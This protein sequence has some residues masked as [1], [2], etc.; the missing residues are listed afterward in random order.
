MNFTYNKEKYQNVRLHGLDQ[1]NRDREESTP[2]VWIDKRNLEESLDLIEEL[3]YKYIHIQTFNIDFLNDDRLKKIEGI[4]IQHRIEDLSNFYNLNFSQIT[5]LGLPDD[6][7][8][9]FDFSLC[10]NLLY[11]GGRMPKYYKNIDKLYKL[12]YVRIFGYRKDNFNEFKELKNIRKMEVYSMNCTNLVGLSYLENLEELTLR[13]C[14]KLENLE[15]INELNTQLNSVK[16]SNCKRLSKISILRKLNK[17]K[18]LHLYEI[19]KIE[20]LEFLKYLD[21]IEDLSIN[22][23]VVGVTNADYYP[24]VKKLKELNQLSNLKYWD[25]LKEYLNNEVII[26]QEKDEMLS[27]LQLVLMRSPI[28]NWVRDPNE[29]YYWDIYSQ[30]N[31]DKAQQ[32]MIDLVN[33][34][35]S[36]NDMSEERKVECFK[37]CILKLNKH[38]EKY[39]GFIETVEREELCDFFDNLADAAGINVLDYDDGIADEWREW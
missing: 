31:C 20:S 24:L 22:P 35:E 5:H 33:K 28:L 32:F 16:L 8:E 30:Q 10:P 4:S 37:E 1:K 26:A 38:N 25:K 23:E 14:P 9:V 29:E 2:I 11:L 39:S 21:S 12:K 34:L 27:E 7:K 19:Y 36:K 15:G 17:L 13:K 6:I 18:T 3:D